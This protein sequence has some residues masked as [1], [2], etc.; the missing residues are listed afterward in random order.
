MRKLHLALIAALGGLPSLAAAAPKPC[1]DP[2]QAWLSEARKV[3]EANRKAKPGQQAPLPPLVLDA[4][5]L[6]CLKDDVLVISGEA[7]GKLA[8]DLPETPPG[9]L[10]RCPPVKD[11]AGDPRSDPANCTVDYGRAVGRAL[12]LIGPVP[13]KQWDQIV[14]FG[15]QMSPTKDPPG[16]LFFRDWYLTDDAG[17]PY[18]GATGVNEVDNIGLPPAGLMESRRR[19]GRPLVGY[20]GAGGTNQVIKFVD[21]TGTTGAT[22]KQVDPTGPVSLYNYCREDR[23][24]ANDEDYTQQH[25][26]ALCYL[27]FYNFFDA[28]AQ[29]TGSQF[30]PY[31]RGPLDLM[32]DSKGNPLAPLTVPPLSKTNLGG[33]SAFRFDPGSPQYYSLQPSIWNSFLDMQGSLFAG[34]TFRDNGDGTF[35]TT[36]P[37]PFQGIN[38]PFQGG[39]RPGTV[40]AGARILRF[41]PLDLYL[42]GFL[43][44]EEVPPTIRAFIRL[45]PTQLVRP[46]LPDNT[47]FSPFYGP[48]MGLRQ[49][50]ALKPESRQGGGKPVTEEDITI[51]TSD[52]LLAN[53]GPRSPAFQD[54]PH[55]I[56][57][58]WV[59]VT[60]PQALI[61]KD[62]KD[63]AE[64]QLKV[65]ESLQHLEAV[66]NWRH[67]FAAYFYMLT[68]YRG[69][70]I[71]T[72]DGFDDNAYFEFGQPFDDKLLF[73]PDEGVVAAYPGPERVSPYKPDIKNVL[74]INATPGGGAG[75]TY[76]GKPFPLR[77]SGNQTANRVPVNAVSVRMRVPP[78][79]PKGAVATL[80]LTDGPELRLPSNCNGRAGCKESSFLVNDGK[81]HTYSANLAANPAF[82]DKAFTGFKFVPSDKGFD[83]GEDGIEIDYIRVDHLTSADD[84]DQIRMV[85]SGCAGLGDG[86]AKKKCQTLCQTK[87]ASDPVV[88]DLP[89]GF[90]DSTDNCP[91]TYNPLQ[92]DGDGNGTGDACEDFDGDGAVNA[93]DNC[94]VLSNSRQRDQDGDGVGDVCDDSTAGGCFLK[95][96]SLGGSGARGPTALVVVAIGGLAGLLVVRRRRKK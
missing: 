50:I 33:V 52:I 65:A 92:E 85:C 17:K 75:L 15:Q 81:W 91:S 82:V 87:A 25:N 19:A 12:E 79:V 67:Q 45:V 60:K 51:K 58:L 31:L 88:V 37:P 6:D 55:A 7:T 9:P 35:S 47:P 22:L 3:E 43:P 5:H 44:I 14:V 78:S 77:I 94:P 74:R 68:Q 93:W 8:T 10:V 71:T 56:K 28:L 73:A 32:P 72:Y 18:T 84:T 30:G 49:G 23:R 70:V 61:E 2:L 20:I 95:S 53:G 24:A 83:A 86:D 64:K 40:L 1:S 66:V 63:D 36:R 46:K 48:M 21:T 89:D 13:E 38:L 16:P 54:A 59:V 69:R 57:Q 39:W 27:G 29:A 4:S 96:S 76:T 34:N 80:A 62:A 90:L 41:Q 11:P 26:P 42:M